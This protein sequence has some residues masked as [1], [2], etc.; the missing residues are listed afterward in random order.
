MSSFTFLSGIP[1]AVQRLAYAVQQLAHAVQQLA[2]AM[3]GLGFL[4]PWIWIV[5]RT[6]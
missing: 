2:C 4:W 5:G 6:Y 1:C 3:Q